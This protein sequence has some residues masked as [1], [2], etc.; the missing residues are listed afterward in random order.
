[1]GLKKY[2]LGSVLLI[3]VVFAYTFSIESGD[4][5]V[6]L[7]DS[8]I[9]LPVAAWVVVP[10]I[11]LFV[12]S[13]LHIVF[14]GMKNY[15]EIKSIKKDTSSL[16]NLLNKKLLKEK[17]NEIFKNKDLK[18]IA[19]T[20]SQL[21]IDI[22]DTNFS[23]QDNNITK[24]AKQLFEIRAGKFVSTKELKLNDTNPIMV[25]NI[26]NKV[27]IDDDYALEIVKNSK[28][29]TPN[30]VKSAFLRVL[31]S[32]SIT[33]VKKILEDIK[34][35]SDMLMA[36]FK[37]DS[38][39]KV[40]FAMDNEAIIKLLKSVT[41]SNSQLIQMANIYKQ[42]MTPDQ[43][44]K[45]F[46]DLTTTDESYTVVYLYVLS[47]YEMLDKMRDIL[48]NSASDEYLPFKALVDLKDAGKHT[49]SL[50]NLCIK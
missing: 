10:A 23:S 5:R 45:L 46:E 21:D 26:L 44:I 38:E 6:E 43:I 48:E 3:L 22:T 9:L 40:D 31:E 42:S 49:Y 17:T 41:L 35:D 27:K 25:E 47:Q 33:T 18:E 19:D 36:L 15:F 11:V 29:Y 14:Y 28:K 8:V 37:K 39:Q 4:Y 1:M 32:K 16:K 7:L 12:L 34:L 24:T 30:I 13:V 20:L 50:D 2:I